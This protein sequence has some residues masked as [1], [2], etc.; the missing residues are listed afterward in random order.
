MIIY[1]F[2]LFSI[3][4]NSVLSSCSG[5]VGVS[6]YGNDDLHNGVV[7]FLTSAKA[8]DELVISVKNQVRLQF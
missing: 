2:V 5:A 1:F 4:I 3:N 8:L 6:L 7:Q